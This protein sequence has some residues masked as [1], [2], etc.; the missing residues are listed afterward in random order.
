MI[1]RDRIC[2]NFPAATVWYNLSVYFSKM[3]P[4]LWVF[5]KEKSERSTLLQTAGIRTLE[6]GRGAQSF[7]HSR[8]AMKS[9]WA[10]RRGALQPGCVGCFL[11]SYMSHLR[12]SAKIDLEWSVGGHQSSL[13]LNINFLGFRGGWLA[14]NI[15]GQAEHDS[16][17]RCGGCRNMRVAFLK[18]LE[19]QNKVNGCQD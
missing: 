14:H 8:A 13:F 2:F 10:A 4:L 17:N 7:S 6:S 16:H 18:I 1:S 11:F 3:F 15:V 19:G 12:F 5:R 9:A